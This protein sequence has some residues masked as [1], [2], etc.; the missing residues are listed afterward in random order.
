MT[1]EEHSIVSSERE[2]LFVSEKIN[3]QEK[4]IVTPHMILSKRKIALANV[5][6]RLCTNVTF[7]VCLLF[8]TYS[9]E[10]LLT[11]TGDQKNKNA[12]NVQ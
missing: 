6:A 12:I 8:L 11:I 2:S 5:K 3:A 9:N 10:V 1:F 7:L 4:E